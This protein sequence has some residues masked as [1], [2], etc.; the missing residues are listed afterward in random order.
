M[1]TVATLVDDFN[2]GRLDDP[3]ARPAALPRLVRDRQPD[4]VDAAGWRAIDDAEIARGQAQGRPR[5]KFTSVP[6]MLAAA[7]QRPS[8]SGRLWLSRF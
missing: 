5:V 2:A 4:V 3:V 1:H 8:R 7:R 6:Q